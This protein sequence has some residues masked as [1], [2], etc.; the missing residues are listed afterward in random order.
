MKYYIRKIVG[1]SQYY[2]NVDK[3]RWEGLKC[4]ATYFTNFD[5]MIATRKKLNL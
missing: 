1:S 3:Q 2:Y 4:N 5:E